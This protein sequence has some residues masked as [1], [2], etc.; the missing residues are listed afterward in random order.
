MGTE[1][2]HDIANMATKFGDSTNRLYNNG[3]FA[4]NVQGASNLCHIWALKTAKKTSDARGF[5]TLV[6]FK[7]SF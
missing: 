6:L 2:Q 5:M 1:H 3:A 7:I 4:I